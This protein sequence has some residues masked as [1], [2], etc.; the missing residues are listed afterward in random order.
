MPSLAPD[1]FNEIP[2]RGIH[3]W[4]TTS[5]INRLRIRGTDQLKGKLGRL[6]VHDFSPFRTSIDVTVQTRLV[7]QLARINLDRIDV[8]PTQRGV[9]FTCSVGERLN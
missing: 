4:R 8:R 9:G 5:D 7:T 1:L 2:E 6:A 3:L